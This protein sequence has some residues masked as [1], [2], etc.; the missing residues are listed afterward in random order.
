MKFHTDSEIKHFTSIRNRMNEKKKITA[1]RGREKEN[2][3]ERGERKEQ[4]PILE[5]QTGRKQSAKKRERRKRKKE[6]KL[7]QGKKK[8]ERKKE[9]AY[10]LNDDV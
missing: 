6:E 3:V 2:S 1:D 10:L 8:R 7:E 4:Q 9:T 5:K